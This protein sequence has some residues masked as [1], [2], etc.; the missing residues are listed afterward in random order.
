M[1]EEMSV[2][3]MVVHP[4][5]QGLFCAM[6]REMSLLSSPLA[7]SLTHKLTAVPEKAQ[8]AGLNPGVPAPTTQRISRDSSRRPYSDKG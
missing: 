3:H 7:F 6:P 8:D 1:C 5:A 2:I 4:G